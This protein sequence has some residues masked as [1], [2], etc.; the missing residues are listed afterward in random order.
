MGSGEGGGE[1][2]KPTERPTDLKAP[3]REWEPHAWGQRGGDKR[4]M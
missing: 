4:V 1:G 2:S 3:P